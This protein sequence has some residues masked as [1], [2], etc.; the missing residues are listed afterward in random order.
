[1][2]KM[3]TQKSFSAGREAGLD[4]L[5]QLEKN[6]ANNSDALSGLISVVMHATYATAPTEEMAEEIITL[7]QK[8]ALEDWEQEKRG[9]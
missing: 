2:A 7:S 8:F 5:E 1:M 9:N 4:A 6:G 3:N